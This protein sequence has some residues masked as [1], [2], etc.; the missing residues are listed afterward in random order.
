MD[1]F[2]LDPNIAFCFF[3]KDRADLEALS[4]CIDRWKGEGVIQLNKKI[5]V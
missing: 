2:D 5:E 3:V 4:Q 1:R